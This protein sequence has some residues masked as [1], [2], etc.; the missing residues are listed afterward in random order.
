MGIPVAFAIF[1]LAE[2]MPSARFQLKDKPGILNFFF[3]IKSPQGFCK[4]G[5]I[6]MIENLGYAPEVLRAIEIVLAATP[7]QLKEILEILY[8]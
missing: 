2:V 5:R 1:R 7:E 4:G 8:S 6:M 3:A